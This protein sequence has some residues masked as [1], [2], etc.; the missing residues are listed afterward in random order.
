MLNYC[1]WY[2]V[3]WFDLKFLD[4]KLLDFKWFAVYNCI[5]AD[6]SSVKHCKTVPAERS[7]NK[8]DAVSMVVLKIIWTM[9]IAGHCRT[10]PWPAVPDW[11]CCRNADGKSSGT[12][13]FSF[14]MEQ[15]TE[16]VQKILFL[17]LHPQVSFWPRL[18]IRTRQISGYSCIKQDK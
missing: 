18:W 15:N 2:K 3:S 13:F 7:Y 9:D 10:N 11:P 1:K 16:R 12:L 6:S 5:V 14:F 8:K 4:F 17:S